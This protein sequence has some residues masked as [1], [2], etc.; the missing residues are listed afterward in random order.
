VLDP[1][2]RWARADVLSTG[3]LTIGGTT[4]P[5]EGDRARAVQRMLVDG[6]DREALA[7]AGVGWVV[8][9][10]DAQT[11]SGT[12][13]L[14]QEYRDDD[15]AVYRVGGDQVA[16]DHR[17]LMV[18]VH[19]LWLATLGAGAAGVAVCAALRRRVRPV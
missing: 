10:T 19:L 18:V 1:L 6:A 11:S 13:S 3:D 15:I 2:P 4:V 17:G 7:R 14:P 16:T 5:G 9:E 8:V 12:L